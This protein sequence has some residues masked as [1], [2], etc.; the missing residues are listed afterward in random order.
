MQLSEVPSGLGQ[1]G[2]GGDVG[3]VQVLN[4]AGKP[5]MAAG[6]IGDDG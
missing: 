4:F 5:I 6:T 1:E 3:S 2:S